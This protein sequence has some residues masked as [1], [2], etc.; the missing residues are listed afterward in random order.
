MALKNLPKSFK[1]LWSWKIFL[2][3]LKFL[4]PWK[5][6]NFV[7]KIQVLGIIAKIFLKIH[8]LCPWKYSKNIFKNPHSV[9][10][11]IFQKYCYKSTYFVLK[12]I[13][14]KDC[15]WFL[16]YDSKSTS[17]VH[18]WFNKYLKKKKLRCFSLKIFPKYY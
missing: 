3:F 16:K 13:I 7:L 9:F 14:K 8:V 1:S 12:S 2:N 4:G 17:F 15:P 18:K 11:K 6:S 5:Y 10:L